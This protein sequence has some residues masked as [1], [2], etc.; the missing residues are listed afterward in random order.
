VLT[1]MRARS[2]C[3]AASCTRRA[4]MSRLR[5]AV[6]R[7][8]TPR[9]SLPS[10]SLGASLALRVA[11]GG[12]RTAWG[13]KLLLPRLAVRVPGRGRA[14]GLLA[15]PA[16]AASMTP[17]EPRVCPVGGVTAREGWGAPVSVCAMSPATKAAAR[18][19]TRSRSLAATSS[20]KAEASSAAACAAALRAG[21]C[22]AWSSKAATSARRRTVS[23]FTSLQ[24]HTGEHG[25]A[26]Y[27][28]A[29]L[30]PRPPKPVE[31][32]ASQP[33]GPC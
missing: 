19:S 17:L 8:D 11:A 10:R 2:L 15:I 32:R 33:T 26:A 23:V 28:G 14:E 22:A 24:V 4:A 31:A 25:W 27:R 1:R 12:G 9:C 29:R 16:E 5:R 13:E 18:T 20:R 21:T 6:K 30:Q 7:S 3:A